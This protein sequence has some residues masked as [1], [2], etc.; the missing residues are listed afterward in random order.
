MSLDKLDNLIGTWM[1]DNVLH[2]SWM[3]P[4][5]FHSPSELTIG[6]MVRDKFLTFNYKWSHENTPHEGLLLIGYDAEKEVVNATWVDSWHSSAKPLALSGTVDEQGAM[7]LYGTYEVPNH[8]DW[9]WRIV[10]N[11][12][13]DALQIEMFNVTPEAEEDLAVRADYKKA[14]KEISET[15]DSKSVPE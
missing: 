7:N 3:N 15:N 13:E 2:L 14:R 12:L 5:E 10:V 8:P 9:G 11:A 6:R 4:S 1:G